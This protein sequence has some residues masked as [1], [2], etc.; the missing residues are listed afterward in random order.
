[1]S[2]ST[3]SIG[4]S[5]SDNPNTGGK[6]PRA[7]WPVALMF[8]CLLMTVIAIAAAGGYWAGL[9]ERSIRQTQTARDAI[10]E[11]FR[12]A[13]EDLDAGRY[14]LARQRLEYVLGTDPAY[15]GAADRLALA[16]RGM[17]S[18]PALTPSPVVS[19]GSSAAELFARAQAQL[20]Q[21]DWD[22]MITTLTLLR[23]L[24]AGYEAVRVDGMLYL[25]LRNRGLARI[26]ADQ[27]E[28]GLFDLT[29]AEAFGPLDAE[30]QAQRGWAELYQM[31][32][33]FWNIDWKKAAYYFSE[34]YA[35]APYFKDTNLKYF[36]ATRNYADQLFAINDFC[37]A[38]AQYALALRLQNDDE[39]ALRHDAAMANCISTPTPD[40]FATPDP[41]LT[42][43]STDEPTSDGV[44]PTGTPLP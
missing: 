6:A 12:L 3:P 7:F 19:G 35:A 14:E 42:P 34:L 37:N 15:P 36:Q 32:N 26:N 23:N 43:G 30:A 27:L 29:R 20:E 40:P 17:A 41:L 18:T 1:M 39:L 16:R 4:P 22:A 31:A 13:A 33:S 38:E 25:G 11:Q 44:M 8:V 28:E 5:P 10:D 2:G 21:R 24:D 9:G